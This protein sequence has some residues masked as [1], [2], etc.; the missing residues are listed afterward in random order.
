MGD[1]RNFSF[2]DTERIRLEAEDQLRRR[3]ERDRVRNILPAEVHVAGTEQHHVTE[4]EQRAMARGM[5][6]ARPPWAHEHLFCSWVPGAVIFRVEDEQALIFPCACGAVLIHIGGDSRVDY[7]N[8][9]PT[10]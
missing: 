5:R 10:L 8:A 4:T 3:A 2:A 1:F 7:M 6:Q 9:E